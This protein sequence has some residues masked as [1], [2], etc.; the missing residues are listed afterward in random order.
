MINLPSEYYPNPETFNPERFDQEY[1]GVKAFKDRRV[2]IPFG[3]G[4]RICSGMRFAYMQVKA[5]I[6]EVVRSFEI[7]VDKQTPKNLK[8]SP[9]EFMN[10][11]DH[12]LN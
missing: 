7:L 8:I 5:A 6:T 12:T 4:P 1:G 2:L 11:P 3:D 9:T 10:V